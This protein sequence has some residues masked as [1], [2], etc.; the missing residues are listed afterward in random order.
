MQIIKQ[1]LI[2]V[3]EQTIEY[4]KKISSSLDL[5][6]FIKNVIK[7]DQEPEE[8][9]CLIT[10]NSP[11]TINSFMEVA[12][13]DINCCNVSESDIY[14]RVFVSN[15]KK[16]ILVHNHPSGITT[17]SGCDIRLT[18]RIKKSSELLDLDFLDHMIIGNNEY[19]SCLNKN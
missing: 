3:Q 11:N 7:L 19:Y 10:L 9:L 2:L 8:V 4:K 16:F 14:K 17:P 1:K 5:Y 13:G 6:N 18:S 15:C 12:R